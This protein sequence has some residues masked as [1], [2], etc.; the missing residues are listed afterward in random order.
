[1]LKLKFE[2]NRSAIRTTRLIVHSINS[3]GT[4]VDN[5]IPSTNRKDFKDNSKKKLKNRNRP[6]CRKYT[7]IFARFVE[8]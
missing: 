8:V 7:E 1:M 2:R 5:I 4:M 3:S 6:V